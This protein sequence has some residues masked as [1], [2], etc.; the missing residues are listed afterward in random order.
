MAE[1]IEGRARE[2]IEAPNFCYLATLRKDG[3]PHVNP[4]WVDIEDG[5]VLLNSAEGRAWPA[6]LRR[7]GQATLIVPD[8]DNPYEYVEIRGRLSGDTHEGADGHIDA[9]AKKY[10][11]VDE[12]PF[13]QPGEQRVIFKIEPES[14]FHYSPGG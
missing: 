7:E 10:L 12:Y 3:T 5:E 11:G 6:N 14:V 9:L 8:K 13:R 2:L 4:T 1:Q